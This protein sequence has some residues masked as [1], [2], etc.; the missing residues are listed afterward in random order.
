MPKR[1]FIWDLPTRLFHWLLVLFFA[2][3]YG[4]SK[5]GNDYIDWHFYSGYGVL[6]LILFRIIWGV[7]GTKFAL[8]SQLS[9][10]PKAVWGYAKRLF[11]KREQ[12]GLPRFAGH[13]PLGSVMVV[14]LLLSILIQ[15]VSGLF[16]DDE[17]F[18]TGPY[19]G[20]L[21]SGFDGVM[22]LLHHNLIDFILWAI[23][24]HI[25][26]ALFYKWVKKQD[27]IK[28]MVTGYKTG[29]DV[30]NTDGIQHSK[31]LVALIVA[32]VC[33]LFVYWLV[34]LNAPI[35]EDWY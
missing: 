17:I 21:G 27:L 14:F 19:N 12:S 8:F 13:N 26:A 9:L 7:I 25:G 10:H 6:T 28:S 15:A 11:L 2:A 35:E 18:T 31:W 23:G 34:V 20:S 24:F 1:I 29:A 16:M 33:C 4:F 3:S 32:L 30:E 5:L 22:S